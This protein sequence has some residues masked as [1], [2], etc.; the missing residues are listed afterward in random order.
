MPLAAP[1]QTVIIKTP[2]ILNNTPNTT[3]VTIYLKRLQQAIPDVKLLL[4][5]KNP[6]DR[7]VSHIVHEYQEWGSHQ[8]ETMPDI[9]DIIMG[10]AGHIQGKILYFFLLLFVLMKCFE[11]KEKDSLF[12]V[13]HKK[14]SPFQPCVE[15]DW[16]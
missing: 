4:V 16:M 5:V 8:N 10:R 11:T 13:F 15:F 1:D 12:W 6:I 9:D 3:A 7:I 2:G 14:I